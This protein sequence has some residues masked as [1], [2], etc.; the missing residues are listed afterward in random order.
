MVTADG[1]GTP[2]GF[3][4]T[5]MGSNDLKNWVT[6]S[7]EIGNKPSIKGGCFKF[8]KFGYTFTNIKATD[9]F[10]GTAVA[11]QVRFTEKFR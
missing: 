11:S 8:Y 1:V 3:K 4:M 5:V 2:V 6:L 10:A 7:A 9:S